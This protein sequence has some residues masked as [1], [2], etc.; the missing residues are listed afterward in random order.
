MA[1]TKVSSGLI[2]TSIVDNG[3]ATAITID[4]SENVGIGGSP[5]KRLHVFG[6]DGAGEG[7]PTFNANS[8]AVFQNNGTS[9]DATILNI[10]AGS[11]SSG[12]IG[13]G[14]STDDIRQ[15][16]VANMS[17]DSLE[18]RTGNNSTALTISSTGNVGIGISPS[19]QLD[20]YDTAAAFA[21][22]IKNFNGSDAGGGLWIDTRWNTAANR[23]LKITSNNEGTSLF[24]VT[25][26]GNVGIGT[27]APQTNLEIVKVVAGDVGLLVRNANNSTGDSATLTLSAGSAYSRG[28]YVKSILTASGGTAA[29][30]TFGTNT[31]YNTATE[32]MRIDSSGNL[33]VGTTSNSVYNDVSGT[34]IALNAGQIQIAGTGATLYLNRQGSDGSIAEFRK[35][36][37]SVGSIGSYA[38]TRLRIGSAGGTGILFGGTNLYPATDENVADNTH[39][40]GSASYR[41]KNVYRAGSTYSTS[42]RNMKQDIRE[43]TDA[44]RNVAVACKGLLKAF[45]FIDTVEKDGDDANIHFGIIAQELAA[46]FTAEGL[47][48][49]DYQ[50]Y[51]S[52]V[53][54]DEDG[55][56]QTRLNVC[57]E[58]LLA[59]I[60]AAI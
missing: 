49:N 55:N 28:S 31:A 14:N 15:A 47:D 52:A 38:S 42:D 21:A 40:V 27:S 53:V 8:V 23:P 4:S 35:S 50:V 37:T 41:W 1:L 12:F 48:A 3:N 11:A 44:E 33:L 54:T 18:L 36:G 19:Y 29:A 13:F 46:S 45:R 57:Y 7:T 58:N 30:L 10:V 60:I 43:L 9:A 59:F 24:E 6:P 34:G 22:K 26:T 39:D 56:E 16:I 25:G 17:N 32:R 5:S 51:K 20:V 2:N